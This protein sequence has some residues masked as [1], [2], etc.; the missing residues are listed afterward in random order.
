[1]PSRRAVLVGLGS[2]AAVVAAGRLMRSS[3][4]A[5]SGKCAALAGKQVRWIVPNAPGGGYDAEARLIEPFF[6]QQIGAEI[7]IENEAGA[8]GIVGAR[9]IAM[10]PPD[11]LTIGSIGAPGLL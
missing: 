3:P 7:A 8:G 1:M 10:A 6:E 2:A 9:A 11:G 5:A 4:P